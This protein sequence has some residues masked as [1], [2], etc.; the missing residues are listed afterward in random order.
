MAH[1]QA[2]MIIVHTTEILNIH[3]TQFS[4]LHDTPGCVI[5]IT[6]NIKEHFLNFFKYT[7][8]ISGFL[9]LETIP[10]NLME[11]KATPHNLH[12]LPK[13]GETNR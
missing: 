4:E 9:L 5:Q 10:T 11:K 12:P 7:I 8:Q 1:P 2:Y 3:V 6:T 13:L